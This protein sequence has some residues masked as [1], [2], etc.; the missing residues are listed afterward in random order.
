MVHVPHDGDNGSTRHEIAGLFFLIG[1]LLDLLLFEGNYLNDS[2][3]RFRESCGR[4]GVESLIDAREYT[5]VQQRF[6]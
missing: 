6:Q 2:A 3:E 5:L 4:L 1:F